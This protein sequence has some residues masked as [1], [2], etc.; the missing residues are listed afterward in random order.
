M[1]TTIPLAR[2]P[3]LLIL[4]AAAIAQAGPVAYR[5]VDLD[6]GRNPFS[7]SYAN[8]ISDDNVIVGYYDLPVHEGQSPLHGIIWPAVKPGHHAL[9]VASGADNAV[10]SG[11]V[12]GQVA[13]FSQNL[14]ADE[15]RR[16]HALYWP[17][18]NARPIDLNP[19]GF[20][21]SEIYGLDANHQVGSGVPPT[22][23]IHALLFSGSGKPVVDLNPDIDTYGASSAYGISH[24]KIVGEAD[25]T[26]GPGPIAHAFL[27]LG[28][29]DHF[30][31]LNPAGFLESGAGSIDPVAGDAQFGGGGAQDG[32]SHALL[33][34]NTAD[35]VIDL[36]PAGFQSTFAGGIYGNTQVGSGIPNDANFSHALVWHGSAESAIDLHDFLPPGEFVESSAFAVN[37]HGIIVGQA[38]TRAAAWVPVAIPLPAPMLTGAAL[39][40][41]AFTNVCS[42][43][44]KKK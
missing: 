33:W 39:L 32:S 17:D 7:F 43:G 27:W 29:A 6:P 23:L 37:S 19:P 22:G 13:G 11:I 12:G 34:H 35:S 38:G 44:L 4:L 24:N 10:P 26:N 42:I 28:S 1:S 31:D 16:T 3:L 8:G 41:M 2:A 14:Y 40:A 21:H 15:T 5:F 20:L 36:T 9:P 25:I 30:V 18:L